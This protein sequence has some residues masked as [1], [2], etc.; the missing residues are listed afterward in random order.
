MRHSP[1]ENDTPIPPELIPPGV[2]VF[3]IV[4]NP[5]ETR[6]LAEARRRGARTVGGMRMLVYQGAESFRLWTGV[7]PPLEVMLQAARS[8][9]T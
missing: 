8:A 5:P 1:A 3:D 9:V 7:E 2:L 4:A 6:L